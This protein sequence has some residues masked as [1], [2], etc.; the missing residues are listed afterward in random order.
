MA[1]NTKG[2][3]FFVDLDLDQLKRQAVEANRILNGIGKDTSTMNKNTDAFTKKIG[4]NVSHIT[5]GAET[6][7]KSIK[8]IQKQVEESTNVL[9]KLKKYTEGFFAF[10]TVKAFGESIFQVR[11]EMQALETSFEVLVGNKDKAT[12]LF[13]EIKEF[14]VSTPMDMPQLAKGAQTLLSF[15]I[16]QEKVM[17]LLRQIGDISKGNAENFNGL[18]LAYAQMSSAGKL[19]GQDLMQMI[20]RG[21]NPLNEIARTTGKTLAEVKEEMAAGKLTVEDVQHAFET[22]T[23]AGGQFNGMLAKQSQTLGGAMSNLRG[24]ITDMQNELGE[25]LQGTFATAIDL[26]TTLVKNYEK[27]AT[28]IEMVAA[29]YGTYKASVVALMAAEKVKR[30]IELYNQYG[31]LTR[32]LKAAT[33]AQSAYNL[34]ASLNPV[35]A[36]AAGLAAATV[37]FVKLTSYIREAES[38]E[39]M[40]NE[41][42]EKTNEAMEKRKALVNSLI[43][44][45][46]EG[47][48]T[49]VGQ[50]QAYEE[51]KKVARELTDTYTTLQEL[52]SA[53]D[54]ELQYIENGLYDK[55]RLNKN[56]QIYKDTKKEI[57]DLQKQ[58]AEMKNNLGNAG[59]AMVY[60][61][62]MNH[63]S[64]LKEANSKAAKVIRDYNIA[65]QQQKKITEEIDADKT[66]KEYLEEINKQLADN[67]IALKERAEILE[68][69]KTYEKNE[70]EGYK[71]SDDLDKTV[72]ALE[73]EIEREAEETRKRKRD[74]INSIREFTNAEIKAERD[75]AFERQQNT[76]NL[77][78]EGLDKELAQIELNTERSKAAI[79]DAEA[80]KL[81]AYKKNAYQQF[82]A[83][84]GSK[85]EYA[86]WDSKHGNSVKLPVSVERMYANMI[87]DVDTQSEAERKKAIKNAL[88]DYKTYFDKLSDIQ[89]RYQKQRDRLG[90]FMSRG[91]MAELNKKEREELKQLRQE[92]GL[93]ELKDNYAILT[94]AERELVKLSADELQ[95]K[96]QAL[97]ADKVRAELAG[98]MTAE[99]K[100]QYEQSAKQLKNALNV[101]THG[102]KT[103]GNGQEVTPGEN[104]KVINSLA[105]TMSTVS[106]TIKE[107]GKAIS[108]SATSSTEKVGAIVS[109]TSSATQAVGSFMDGLGS[110]YGG[111]ASTIGGIIQLVWDLGNLINT[112]LSD[113]AHDYYKD[114]EVMYEATNKVSD[115]QTN[116]VKKMNELYNENSSKWLSDTAVE[117]MDKLTTS[118]SKSAANMVRAEQAANN[119]ALIATSMAYQKEIDHINDVIK[120]ANSP[121][122]LFFSG[123]HSRYFQ[124]PAYKAKLINAEN[125]KKEALLAAQDKLKSKTGI[126]DV[127]NGKG[128]TVK[129][130]LNTIGY[131]DKDIYKQDPFGNR[132]INWDVV[133]SASQT[134]EFKAFFG[135]W[136]TNTFEQVGKASEEL[137]EQLQLVIENVKDLIG[138]VGTGLGDALVDAFAKGEVAADAFSNTLQTDI[139]NAIKSMISDT[140]YT[141][142]IKPTIDKMYAELT[143]IQSGIDENGNAAIPVDEYMM[144]MQTTAK[145]A[146]KYKNKSYMT[147]MLA[148][149]PYDSTMA[150]T[151]DWFDKSGLSLINV[152]FEQ[153]MK[154]TTEDMADWANQL[155][156]IMSAN[157][158]NAYSVDI[159][160]AEELAEQE[161]KQ[162]M[163]AAGLA[164]GFENDATASA[165]KSEGLQAVTQDSVDEMN[166][167]LTA[168]QAHTFNLSENTNMLVDYTNS[169]LNNV[170][171]INTNTQRLAAIEQSLKDIYNYGIKVKA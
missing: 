40:Y 37:G 28:I 124:A 148:G 15:G 83:K 80:Q 31:Q 156:T 26:A 111:I 105:Q 19:M 102:G 7:A 137:N 121:A 1:Q 146:E 126:L 139:Q 34:V 43:A 70:G 30:I 167:R 122:T 10:R 98:K 119:A 82:I 33:Q 85:T 112:S 130:Y 97:E 99:Q 53:T 171:Q 47:N 24:A 41:A 147:Q 5:T 106:E 25:G 103:S 158:L 13:S 29:A 8:Q 168:I 11:S 150:S 153:F 161:M 72:K 152:S 57:E 48:G 141:N 60:S 143:K 18:V 96:L 116:M 78:E 164:S 94:E 120:K 69:L 91:Q 138:E 46:K 2:I 6:A 14:A 44:K 162:M 113:M 90:K 74:A 165:K 76:I 27:L 66:Q 77:M 84:T 133:V 36:I 23:S 49:G 110:K 71:R 35:G 65:L 75:A 108:D 73:K 132:T 100:K 160:A 63:L 159:K 104:L 68:R 127:I 155:K 107:A 125:Q 95:N 52:R 62:Y 59:Q 88:A 114:F 142:T 115:A 117:R 128:K 20:G 145:M 81:Q 38:G 140:V 129:Q 87:G 55:E 56:R 61:E 101:K 22:A 64:E 16:A 149:V 51:L 79:I 17:P 166:G 154:G 118:Y 151:K 92:Y 58:L 42:M 170:M 131:N 144:Q 3:G 39:K 163:E 157:I 54:E 45:A 9:A 136:V 123:H 134:D 4:E 32:I 21:F 93:D 135:E 169:I 86:E 12:A 50:I 89:E 109:A 67:N